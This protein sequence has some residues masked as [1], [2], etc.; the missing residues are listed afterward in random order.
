MKTVIAAS[1]AMLVAMSTASAQDIVGRWRD[2]TDGGVTE[3]RA[4]GTFISSHP[5]ISMR[6]Q[7][8]WASPG[9][10]R[11]TANRQSVICSASVNGRDMRISDCPMVNGNT[12]QLIY[13]TTARRID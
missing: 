6:G 4:D 9:I 3:Y 7:W 5:N 13:E 2:N 12:G 1:S 10:L 8:N 11:V